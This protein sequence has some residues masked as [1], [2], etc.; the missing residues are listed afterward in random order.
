[1]NKCLVRL[2]WCSYFEIFKRRFDSS[3]L[4][5]NQISKRTFDTSCLTI[6]QAINLLS[7]EI[8]KYFKNFKFWW[9]CSLKPILLLLFKTLAIVVKNYAKADKFFQLYPILLGSFTSVHSSGK[10]NQYAKHFCK[11]YGDIDEKFSADLFED[12]IS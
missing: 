12:S 11:N 4:R 9:I 7:L 5:Q 10:V 2:Q 8:R 1:M 6:C 3:Q